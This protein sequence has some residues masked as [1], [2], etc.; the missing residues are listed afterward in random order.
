MPMVID[1]SVTMAW[2]FEDEATA[3]TEAVLDRLRDD[4]AIVPS[5]WR[6]EVANVLQVAERRRRVS[7][8]QA[9]R[10]IDLLDQLPIRADASLIDINNVRD[11]ARRHGLSAYDAAYLG[12]AERLAAPLAT[13][14]THLAAACRRAAVTLLVGS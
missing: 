12:L 11:L 5:L 4:E 2:C 1:T 8:A 13:L 10:F 14:D 7:E 6:L 3:D 9:T